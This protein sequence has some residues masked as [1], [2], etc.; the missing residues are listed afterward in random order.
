M[1]DGLYRCVAKD[2]TVAA[3][4]ISGG[5]VVEMITAGRI[6]PPARRPRP[7]RIA[8]S[9]SDLTRRAEAERVRRVAEAYERGGPSYWAG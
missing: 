2:G 5:R 8:D 4:Q 6:D 7:R 9:L 3:V 1:K